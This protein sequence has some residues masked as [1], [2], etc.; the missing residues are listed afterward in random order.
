[1]SRATKILS[2]TKIVPVYACTALHATAAVIAMRASDPRCQSSRI[3]P[4]AALA[5]IDP[6]TGFQIVADNARSKGA[7]AS[8][9]TVVNPNHA[10]CVRFHTAMAKSASTPDWSRA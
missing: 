8:S 7:V 10:D 9:T 3:N 1:M 4:V 5:R 6:T 2:T